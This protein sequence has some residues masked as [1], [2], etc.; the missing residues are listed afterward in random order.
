M[1][2]CLPVAV[3][4]FYWIDSEN[5]PGLNLNSP[6]RI[7]SGDEASSSRC[8]CTAQS[9]IVEKHCIIEF[10]GVYRNKMR[11]KMIKLKSSGGDW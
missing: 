5:D 3:R 4:A 10:Y 6:S 1:H 11:L 7:R 9:E 2:Y 8:T